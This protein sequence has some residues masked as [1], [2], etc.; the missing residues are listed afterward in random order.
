MAA[1]ARSGFCVSFDTRIL[2]ACGRVYDDLRCD[3]AAPGVVD[4]I[5]CLALS[6]DR[7]TAAARHF[8]EGKE[9]KGTIR[10]WDIAQ[11]KEIRALTGHTREARFIRDQLFPSVA[12]YVLIDPNAVEFAMPD[13]DGAFAMAV[14]PGDYTLKTFFEGK[15]VGKSAEGLHVGFGGLDLRDAL[16]VGGGESK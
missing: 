11:Q 15:Q 14:T 13:R 1:A 10:L 5:R 3:L 16:S 6:P 7:G 4:G 12:M 2:Y 9:P 8:G